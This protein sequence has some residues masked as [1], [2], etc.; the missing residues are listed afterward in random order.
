MCSS[1]LIRVSNDWTTIIQYKLLDTTPG[2]STYAD[3]PLAVGQTFTDPLAQVSITTVSIDA[4][5][6][7]ATVDITWGPDT[8]APTTPTGLSAS[9]ATASSVKLSWSAATDNRAVTGYRVS[10]GSTVL[11]TVSGT[12]YTDT[13]LAPGSYTWSVAAL[14]AAGNA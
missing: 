9:L 10:R 12:T 11:A 6:N 2:T 3:A 13:G 8:T 14:D 5:T 4:T 1:D 7:A